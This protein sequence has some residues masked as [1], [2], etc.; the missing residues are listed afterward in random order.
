MSNCLNFWNSH[1][2]FLKKTMGT[3][4][5]YTK[6]TLDC[7]RP[8]SGSYTNYRSQTICL[9]Y[10]FKGHHF[11]K[12]LINSLKFRSL[13]KN[14]TS[15]PSPYRYFT[16]LIFY[17]NPLK[18][19]LNRLISSDNLCQTPRWISHNSVYILLPQ[20]VSIVF[21]IVKMESFTSW[22]NCWLTIGEYSTVI[23][24]QY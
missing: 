21:L 2:N 9:K 22:H 19:I 7:V 20:M 4:L 13:P 17:D 10:D 8:I 11:N 15:W 3:P 18:Y 16:E 12:G 24:M 5:V 14:W 6:W 23:K 1:F